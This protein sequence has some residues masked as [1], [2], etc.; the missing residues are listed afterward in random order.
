V[1]KASVTIEMDSSDSVQKI[2]RKILDTTAIPDGDQTLVFDGTVLF[3][4]RTLADYN[5]TR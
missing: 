2:K 5:I 3:D 1:N 4:G